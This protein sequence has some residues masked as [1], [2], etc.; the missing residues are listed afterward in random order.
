MFG[1]KSLSSERLDTLRRRGDIERRVL[2]RYPKYRESSGSSFGSYGEGSSGLTP[3]PTEEG[4]DVKARGISRRF[5][6]DM[7]K[8]GDSSEL[9]SK[10]VKHYVGSLVNMGWKT[11]ASAAGHLATIWNKYLQTQGLEADEFDIKGGN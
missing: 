8:A 2:S 10:V 9:K 7:L 1:S 6:L 5:I 11:R 4:T 3:L